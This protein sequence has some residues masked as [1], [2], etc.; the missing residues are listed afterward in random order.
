MTYRKLLFLFLTVSIF[1]TASAQLNTNCPGCVINQAQFGSN[2][3][4]FAVGLFPDTIVVRQ[5]SQVSIDVTYLLP[6]LAATGISIAPTATVNEVQ[7]LGINASNPIPSGLSV[8]C[9][10]SANGCAYYPQT[11]RFGCVKICGITSDAA[12]NGYV[13][14]KI[15]VAGTGSAAGQTQTQNQD[16]DFYYM[17]L[18]DTTACHTV[19]FQNHISSGCD[20]A[21]IGVYPGID[22]SC[23]N[24]TLNPCTFDWVYGNGQTGTGL[25][26][27]NVSYTA[28]G[29]YPV[30]LTKKTKKLVLSSATL[31][32][33]SGW[34]NICNLFGVVSSANNYSLNISIGTNSNSTSGGGSGS[35]TWN[36]LN[37]TVDNQA[38]AIQV[39]DACALSNLSSNTA[40]LTVTGPGVYQWS[41]TGSNAA[42]GTI[43]IVQVDKDST[44]YTDSVHIYPSPAQPVIMAAK[45]SICLGDSVR[46][47]IGSQYPGF[48]IKWYQDSTY[49]SGY[50]DSA[51]YVSPFANAGYSVKVT[52]PRSFCHS[53]SQPHAI[54]V[55]GNPPVAAPIY[56]DG[57]SQQLFLNPYVPGCIVEWYY[58]SNLVTGHNGGTLPY[59]G[60]GVYNAFEYPAGFPQCGIQSALFTL[61]TNVGI[62]EE[63]AD[64]YNMSVYPNPSHGS[65]AVRVN[66]L[67]AG[68]VTIRLTDM[69]GREM[70]QKVVQSNNGEVKD[71]INVA[72]ISKGVYTIEVATAKGKATRRVVID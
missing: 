68:T 66:V 37:Y 64:I 27:Q 60:D 48:D 14:A 59:L 20:S 30:T 40:T 10:Q 7:I 23:P 25:N 33:T 45:D 12:T 13:K 19:C 21:T 52:D 62:A 53:T 9:D 56:Y 71:N 39:A 42:N 11:F 16:I 29:D 3:S 43:T 36:G 24:A 67:T 70:Y 55:S 51:I 22:I 31:S 26:S 17:V 49:L 2:I 34:S 72:D 44:T 1:G 8:T 63:S 58:D 5:N 32:G 46:L 28:P 38:I 69:L 6:K 57:G 4:D 65:F 47:T 35:N 50:T 15:T 61:S 41:V 18:P 54:A